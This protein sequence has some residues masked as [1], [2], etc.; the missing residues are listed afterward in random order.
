[1]SPIPKM[2]YDLIYHE[3][4]VRSVANSTRQDVRELLQLAAEV[5]IRTKVEEYPLEQANEALL[6]VKHS[7]TEAAAVLKVGG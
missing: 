5:P 1:M 3:R 7:R 6:A 4:T 2:P